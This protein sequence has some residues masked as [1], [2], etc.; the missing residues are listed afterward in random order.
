M[1]WISYLTFT[2]M[3]CNDFICIVSVCKNAVQSA[4]Q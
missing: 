3:N 1:L 4:G 2:S